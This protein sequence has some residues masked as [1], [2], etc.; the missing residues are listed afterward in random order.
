MLSCLGKFAGPVVELFLEV[1]GGGTAMPLNRWRI[2]AL[3]LR[4]LTA[5]FFH[6]CA[7]RRCAR[8]ASGHIAAAPLS[9]VMNSRRFTRLPRR[10][11][12]A[13]CLEFEGRAPSR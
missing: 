6:C 12:R 2:A 10:P 5:A 9:S 3:E 13:T 7:T 4:R 8:A 11:A 1:G